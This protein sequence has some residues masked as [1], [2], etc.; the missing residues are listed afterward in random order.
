MTTVTT[1]AALAQAFLRAPASPKRVRQLLRL[2]R[3]HPAV[4]IAETLAAIPDAAV[5]RAVAEA[6]KTAGLFLD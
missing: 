1:P 5:R 6:A 4:Y 3:G 2:L